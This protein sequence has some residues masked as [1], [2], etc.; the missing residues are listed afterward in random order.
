MFQ[1]IAK[2]VTESV[3]VLAME[4][5]TYCISRILFFKEVSRIYF[6]EWLQVSGVCDTHLPNVK[7]ITY[8]YLGNRYRF[9][10]MIK[11]SRGPTKNDPIIDSHFNQE[12]VGP[13]GDYHGC[14]NL[15]YLLA[16][17][18]DEKIT[19]H[20]LLFNLPV[21]TSVAKF[22]Q[23]VNTPQNVSVMTKNLKQIRL[24]VDLVNDNLKQQLFEILDKF[25]L[26]MKSISPENIEKIQELT[27]R[28]QDMK[29]N[30]EFVEQVAEIFSC[31]CI[32][33]NIN[34]L[35]SLI[36]II[37]LMNGLKEI[38]DLAVNTVVDAV[39]D[40]LNDLITDP[41]NDVITD[42]LNDVLIENINN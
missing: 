10:I 1:R 34:I 17:K 6:L 24:I 29:E 33:T 37:R 19:L 25:N 9:P 21:E 15:L 14:Q 38:D 23:F 16:G 35:K 31:D 3:S 4:Y 12:V 18:V 2:L 28:K 32:T 40:P 27:R 36:Y 8:T 41:L 5:Y 20:E 22:L 30:F 13:F 7:W 39:T 26:S 42:P 11:K